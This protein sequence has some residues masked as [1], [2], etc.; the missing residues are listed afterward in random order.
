M[1]AFLG[2][3]T[4]P[5]T[6]R[7]GDLFLKTHLGSFKTLKQTYCNTKLDVMSLDVVNVHQKHDTS[8]YR[9]IYL[10]VMK[11]QHVSLEL[12]FCYNHLCW[13][14]DLLLYR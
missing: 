6:F 10:N 12:M 7:N 1:E 11:Q 2:L 4:E 3:L 8:V 5:L 14:L 13:K 9:V